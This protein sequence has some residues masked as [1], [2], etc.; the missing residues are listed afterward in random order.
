MAKTQDEFLKKRAMRQKKIRRRR[1]RTTIILLFIMAI[2]VFVVLSV[3]VLFPVKNVK[4]SGSKLYTSSEIVKASKINT[5]TNIFTVNESK[6]EDNMRKQLPYIYEVEL[7]RTFPDTLE[8]HITD[9]KPYAAYKCGDKY[10]SV[11]DKG[12]VLE[13]KDGLPA[14]VFEIICDGIKCKIG[15][16]VKFDDEKK[17]ETIDKIVECYKESVYPIKTLDVTDDYDIS[18]T[19]SER[20]SVK[21]GTVTNLEEKC[22]HSI[23]M[24]K[25]ISESDSGMIDVSVW[26]PNNRQGTFV[27]AIIGG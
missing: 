4:V 9:A 20:F 26:T 7:V 14:G 10:Y 21:I 15:E 25:N 11:S 27:R 18:L 24:S 5:K 16:K 22:L 1:I 12:Y 8:I 3:T 19:L 17:Q 6:L 13:E 2:A 23:S